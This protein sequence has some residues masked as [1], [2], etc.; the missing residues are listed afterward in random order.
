[1]PICNKAGSTGK[2]RQNICQYFASVVERN[3]F[4]KRIN[5][6]F[7]TGKWLQ[8]GGDIEVSGTCLSASTIKGEFSSRRED[9]PPTCQPPQ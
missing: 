6:V 9:C 5:G 7:R 1:M 4:G 2:K 8:E 3:P